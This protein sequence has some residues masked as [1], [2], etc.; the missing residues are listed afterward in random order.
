MEIKKFI[1]DRPYLYHLTSKEN[2]QNIIN[3]RRLF[4]TN[5]LIDLSDNIENQKIK[6]ERRIGHIEIK[7][8][9]KTYLLRDQRPISELALSKCL[10]DN[11]KVADFLEHLNNRVFMWPTLDRLWRHYNRYDK[12]NPV[13]L[14]FPSIEIISLNPHAKF[15]RLNSGATRANSYLGGKAPDRGPST[16]LAA[17][18]YNLP[19]R[20]VAEVTFEV[21]CNINCTIHLASSPDGN[22]RLI[23]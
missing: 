15:C 5:K 20:S 9:D 11:W 2:A 22:Y 10:T 21:Q 14:R 6:R 19:V 4:S 18:D 1:Q 13:I 8:G 16:F 17:E 23:K 3:E 7:I 12:E